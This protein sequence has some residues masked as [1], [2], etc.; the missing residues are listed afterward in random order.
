MAKSKMST[1]QLVGMKKLTERGVQTFGHG[2]IVYFLVRPTNI[3]VL[4]ESKVEYK[5]RALTQL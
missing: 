3:S 4:S 2:E 1:I 5:I